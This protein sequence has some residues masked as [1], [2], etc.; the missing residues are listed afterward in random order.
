M[1]NPAEELLKLIEEGEEIAKDWASPVPPP[2]RMLPA[3]YAAL[4]VLVEYAR[5]VSHD[6]RYDAAS[7][8]SYHDVC[9]PGCAAAG[10]LVRALEALKAGR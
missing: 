9:C 10:T 7:E 3:A 2:S 8:F 5:Q 1:T 4:R 6:T